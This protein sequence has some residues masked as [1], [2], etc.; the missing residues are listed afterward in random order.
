[1]KLITLTLGVVLGIFLA[2]NYPD[3]AANIF[4]NFILFAEWLGN[5]VSQMVSGVML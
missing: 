1:M 5:S 4:A 2:Y 3:I